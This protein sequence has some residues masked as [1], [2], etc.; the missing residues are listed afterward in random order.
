MSEWQVYLLRCND[1]SLY[2]GVATDVQRRLL[3]HNGELRGGARYTRSRRPVALVWREACESHG[4]ALKREAEIK[5]LSRPAKL[6]LISQQYDQEQA[7]MNASAE[8]G[9]LEK[10]RSI[11]ELVETHAGAAEQLRTLPPETVEG[12]WRSGLFHH[13]NTSEAGGCE[14]RFRDMIDTWVEMARQ[15]GSVGWIGI[16]NC[17]S[18]AFASAYLPEEGFQRVFRDSGDRVTLGGQFAPNGLGNEEPGGYRLS[19]AW[20][21]GSGT[22]HSAYIA[23]G[24]IPIHD[25]EMLM[26]D[27][28]SGMP[29]MMVAT[30]P[31]EQVT[32]TDGWHVMGLCGTGSYDYNIKDVFVPAGMCYRLFTTTPLRGGS[33]VFRM[34][35]LP[36]TAAGHASFAVGLARRALDEIQKLAIEKT[37]MGDLSTLAHRE[38]FQRNLA[39]HEGMWRAAHALIAQ[40]YT[41]VE[42]RID[43]GAALAVPDRIDMRIASTYATEACKQIVD[44]A[45]LSAGTAAVRDGNLIERIF[46]DMHT[47]TQHT[48]IGEKTYTESA[49]IMLGLQQDSTA[50]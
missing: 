37:R 48:F 34:G 49:K 25:G 18:T 40:T 2:T 28:D 17:P 26:M 8:I 7:F 32:I 21:F 41:E 1:G 47:A 16:A 33:A 10:A 35:I 38:T 20:N 14:P 39:H 24:F 11:C 27:N 30:L 15:D 13:F 23:A 12:L 9:G 45:H 42:T 43:G 22:G 31:R 29:E 4:A 50:V 3:E 36:V 5:A 46:R 6:D 19:G 44:F